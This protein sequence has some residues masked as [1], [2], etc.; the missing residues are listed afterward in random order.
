M[1]LI[2]ALFR[3]PMGW[4]SVASGLVTIF[5]VAGILSA[6]I[7]GVL[8]GV[9]SV[10]LGLAVAAGATVANKAIE[11]RAVARALAQQKETP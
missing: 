4:V 6:P 9:L 3:T 7:V 2:H 11:R 8:Q 1:K 5:G 10:A